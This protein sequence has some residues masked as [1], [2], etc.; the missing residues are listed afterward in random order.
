MSTI[1]ERAMG[2]DQEGKIRLVEVDGTEFGAGIMR[3]H[4]SPRAHT[5]A[6]VLA[7]V[8][9]DDE[10]ALEPVP[11]WWDGNEYGYHAFAV[12]GIS[13]SSEQAASPALHVHNLGGAIS[14]LC[15]H[16]DDMAQAKVKIIDTYAGFIDAANFPAG[17]PTADPQQCFT[18]IYWID[19]KSAETDETVSFKLGSPADLQGQMIPTRQITIL[20][21]W[22]KR[23]E[24]RMNKGCSYAGT[25]YFDE[26]G[27]PVSDPALDVCGG[28]LSDC[29]K[30]FSAG[31][32]DPK[33]A[34]LDFGGF[35]SA[36]LLGR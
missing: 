23:G 14:A 6:E 26:K 2:L 31:L 5:E 32:A 27:N 7:A 10:A 34:I 18:Q 30:R 29:E 25:A 3:F 1:I 13:A 33:A 4:Y 12:E 20:C 19:S 15:I 36:N 8:A 9:A 17:N 22:A 28:C 16:F 35:P 24:Y 11:I 21:E